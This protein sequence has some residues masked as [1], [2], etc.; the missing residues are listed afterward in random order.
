MTR[1]SR[2]GF[3]ITVMTVARRNFSGVPGSV[4]DLTCWATVDAEAAVG[5]SSRAHGES[6]PS[7]WTARS[8]ES[9]CEVWSCRFC[10]VPA[11]RT[12]SGNPLSRASE[13]TVVKESVL[14]LWT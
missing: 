13:M 6:P 5:F 12:I 14:P 1:L 2:E 8:S 11:S 7:R 10:L 4:I 9:R 3:F